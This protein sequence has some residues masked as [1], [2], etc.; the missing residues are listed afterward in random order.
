MIKKL[1]LFLLKTYKKIISPFLGNHCR[2]YPSCATYTHEAIDKYGIIKGLI[3]GIVRI[4]KCHP[5][6][7]GGYDPIPDSFEVQ[8]KWIQ[9]N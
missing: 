4:F 6:H 5:F 7:P 1:F 8:L 2:F 3:L 9:K